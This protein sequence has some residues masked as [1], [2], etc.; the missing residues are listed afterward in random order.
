MNGTATQIKLPKHPRIWWSR[1]KNKWPFLV[2]IL[3]VALAYVL[4]AAGMDLASFI[5]H[6]EAKDVIISPAEEAT[7]QSLSVDVG[8]K[9]TN[10][11]PVAEMDAFLIDAEIAVNEALA[12]ESSNAAADR[13]L[14]LYGNYQ[15]SV[16]DAQTQLE[17]L[18]QAEGTDAAELSATTAELAR[19]QKLKEGG[20]LTDTTVMSRFL[21]REAALKEAVRLYPQSIQATER[22]LAAAKA[23]FEG[24]RKWLNIENETQIT[25]SLIEK[26]SSRVWAPQQQIALL[27][28]RRETYTLRSPADG[29]VSHVLALPGS[30]LSR[31]TP[32]VTVIMA[33][34]RVIGFLPEVYAKD[35]Q[36][37]MDAMVLTRDSAAQPIKA[38]IE[39]VCPEIEALPS[40]TRAVPNQNL[41][42][43]RIYLVIPPDHGLLPG[44]T[45]DVQLLSRARI[46]MRPVSEMV[47]A[48]R[49]F[50]QAFQAKDGTRK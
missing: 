47:Q 9:V 48:A 45:V 41:R 12:N 26:I 8:Q 39:I 19:L 46:W 25:Q 38:T 36:P 15:K 18:K 40:S 11:H 3:A 20:L 5:G 10:N 7:L 31:G 14:G 2:W 32:V 33:T 50:L 13:I 22:R 23:E 1:I 27:R 29:V 24:F 28:Q 30:K 6:V 34:N 4:Y 43:R 44:E 42:G 21:S 37:G 16:T 35:V 49:M 17:Q